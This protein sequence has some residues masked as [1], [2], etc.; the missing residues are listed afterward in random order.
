MVQ[1]DRF[2]RNCGQEL[3]PEDQFC[4]GCGRP[5]HT[6]A[7]VPTPEA[8]VPVPPPPQQSGGGLQMPPR[9]T[10]QAAA[11]LPQPQQNDQGIWGR[12]K[13]QILLFLGSVTVASVL[14]AFADPAIARERVGKSVASGMGLVMRGAFI[15]GFELL[16]NY[17]TLWLVLAGVVYLIAR[18]FGKKPPFL[19]IFFDWLVTIIVVIPILLSGLLAFYQ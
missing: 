10:E 1:Q 19:P 5:V 3:K 9:A 16:L 8:N 4:A 14:D 12:F 18:L 11:P 13:W 17:L 15:R 2:C 7:Y 6:T